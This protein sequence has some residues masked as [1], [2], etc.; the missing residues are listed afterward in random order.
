MFARFLV[1]FSAASCPIQLSLLKNFSNKKCLH[2]ASIS[3][4]AILQ[5]YFFVKN[6]QHKQS[7][8]LKQ[9]LLPGTWQPFIYE[10]PA[11]KI[12]NDE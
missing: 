10:K 4:S 12:V 1:A 7:V 2:N 3:S 6:F 5:I 9:K 8:V 11:K